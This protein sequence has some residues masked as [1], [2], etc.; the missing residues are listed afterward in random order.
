VK[1]ALQVAGNLALAAFSALLALVHLQEGA[2]TGRWV[3][4]L[5]IV[6]EETL[7]VALFLARRGSAGTSSHPVDW[8][9]G[10]GG[11]FLPLLLRP[12]D[13]E[14]ALTRVGE[15]L[16]VVG[17]GLAIVGTLFLG[18]RIGIVAA[19]RGLQTGGAYAL[20]RH[21]MYAAYMLS[22]VGYAITFPSP[23]NIVI[24]AATL[25][26]LHVRAVREERFLAGDPR[27]REYLARVRWRFVPYL[28]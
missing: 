4:M 21:P 12:T 16:Q 27:Y 7:L 25:L 17:V 14:G 18:R 15:P 28:Y 19:H 5:P 26:A 9:S 8:A 23:R 6:V 1:R 10:V 22:Y 2:R 3:T 24:T 11:V 13:P 20:V